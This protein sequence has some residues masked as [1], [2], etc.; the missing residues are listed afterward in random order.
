MPGIKSCSDFTSAF[1]IVCLAHFVISELQ[2]KPAFGADE[3]RVPINK[4]KAIISVF[5]FMAIIV[6]YYNSIFSEPVPAWF[7]NSHNLT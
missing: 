2:G 3:N 1:L 6:E 7:H 4:A 5:C